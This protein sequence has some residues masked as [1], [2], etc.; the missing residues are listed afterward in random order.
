MSEKHIFPIVIKICRSIDNL[1]LT[2]VGPVGSLLCEETFNQWKVAHKPGPLE[3]PY[4]IE[5]LAEQVPDSE[6]KV[7]FARE[8]MHLIANHIGT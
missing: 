2:Y 3:I 4:Y 7:R 5:M 8:A 1:F 6:K